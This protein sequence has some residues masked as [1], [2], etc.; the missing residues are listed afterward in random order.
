M[1]RRHAIVLGSGK[2]GIAAARLLS[3]QGYKITITDDRW[4]EPNRIQL[5]ESLHNLSDLKAVSWQCIDEFYP[6][7]AVISPG[8][9]PRAEKIVSL[10]LRGVY[11]ISELELGSRFCKW[12]IIAITGTNGKTTVTEMLSAN[13]SNAGFSTKAVGNIGEPLCEFVLSGQSVDYLVCEVSSFQLEHSPTFTPVVSAVLNIS[14]DHLDRY[15]NMKHYE[16]TKWSIHKN[17]SHRHTL[18]ISAELKSCCP[19]KE[20]IL[21]NTDGLTIRQK[22]EA[23]CYAISSHLGISEFVTCHT[24]KSFPESEHRREKFLEFAGITFIN[25]SKSTNCHSLENLL[26]EIPGPIILIAGGRDK[27]LDF[28]R[29]EYLIYKKVKHLILLGET[30]HKLAQLWCRTPHTIVDTIEQA[31]EH[32][33]AIACEGDT[34]LLSPACA[35]LDQ[36]SDYKQRGK[37]FK[38]AV[39]KTIMKMKKS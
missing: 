29:I 9:D 15:D 14:E 3:A 8:L 12:P 1:N 33:I 20:V 24:L 32:A 11:V 19:W 21:V 28:R 39:C 25:D 36:F 31:V 7:V 30:K 2:S 4:T 26:T 16:L 22:N 27:R 35:S 38:E 13:L 34:V 17:H 6:E 18:F 37:L 23:F 5:P 10:K